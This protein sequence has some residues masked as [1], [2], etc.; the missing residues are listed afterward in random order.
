MLGLIV[1]FN[2]T[3]FFVCEINQA[4]AKL[5]QNISHKTGNNYNIH[6]YNISKL[7][8]LQILPK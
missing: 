7:P 6:V 5:P 8:K 4:E 1:P 2:D 3:F